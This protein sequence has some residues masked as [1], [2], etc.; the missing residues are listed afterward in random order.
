[1]SGKALNAILPHMKEQMQHYKAAAQHSWT[2]PRR[3]S[4]A[5]RTFFDLAIWKSSRTMRAPSPTYFCTSSLP[6]TRMK[7]ASVRLATAR[8][9]SVFP[10]PGGPY[11][12]TPCSV[13]LGMCLDVTVR[14]THS[15]NTTATDNYCLAGR[16]R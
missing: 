4:A 13:R 5:L 6:M 11:M 3:V 14:R 9:S 12:S 2:C 16:L 10:V 8:A 15:C 7:Q 1:M